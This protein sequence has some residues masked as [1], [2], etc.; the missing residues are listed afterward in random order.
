MLWW[1]GL[2]YILLAIGGEIDAWAFEF[3]AVIAM[4]QV[5]EQGTS[6]GVWVD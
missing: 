3:A 5:M 4:Q 6:W 2:G 1:L